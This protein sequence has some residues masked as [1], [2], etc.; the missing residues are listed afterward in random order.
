MAEKTSPDYEALKIRVQKLAEGPE[1]RSGIEA[2][3]K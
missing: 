2:R 3:L 1:D